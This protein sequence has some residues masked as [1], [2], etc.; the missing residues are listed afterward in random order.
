MNYRRLGKSGLLLSELSLGLWHNFGT[1]DNYA[2]ARAMILAA[3]ENGI[4]VF[5]L[6][7]NYG[8]PP[9]AA[10]KTFGRILHNDLSGERNRMVITSKAGYKMWEGP[11]GEWGSRK[12][13]I[14]SCEESL[15]RMH[16]DYV[17]IF[18]SHRYDPNTPLEETMGALDQIVKS[19]KALYAGLS[20]YPVDK[21]REAKAILTRLGTPCVVDQL[22]YS[23]LVRE[24][25]LAHFDTH[26]ELGMG[27]VSFS[28]L[29]QGQLTDRYAEGI[30]TD[31]RAAK[32]SGFLQVDEVVE[33]HDKVVELSK[34]AAERGESLAQ[35]AL[36]WQL[37]PNKANGEGASRVTSVIIGC[38][39]LSQL[40]AN[41]DAL[42]SQPF[43][44]EQLLAIDNITL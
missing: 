33:N 25:E 41:L 31:S 28:P 30:P 8:P 13:L 29:A 42:S 34:V 43:S 18:Y 39:K 15:G 27:C 37:Y 14:S 23:M 7:N 44:D 20:N 1:D 21:L 16:I 35:M 26:A 19:G 9:G 5:D 24:P 10:E 22:K 17:D 12:Y 32:Q 11:Y 40:M 36:A 6:A 38:S 4:T 2:E 3:Y